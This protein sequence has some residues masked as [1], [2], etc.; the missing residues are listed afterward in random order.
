MK[1][2]LALGAFFLATSTTAFAEPLSEDAL[3]AEVN[4][5]P[6]PSIERR[7]KKSAAHFQSLCIE[8]NAPGDV[9]GAS[10]ASLDGKR[11]AS[12]RRQ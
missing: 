8:R 1:T 2:L 3:L 6:T 5:L 4:A 10:S 11:L 9:K 12:L 7:I